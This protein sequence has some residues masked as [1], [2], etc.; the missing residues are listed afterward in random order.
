MVPSINRPAQRLLQVDMPLTLSVWMELLTRIRLCS[1][2]FSTSLAHPS[3]QATASLITTIPAALDR[4]NCLHPVRSLL[5]TLLGASSSLLLQ[6][7]LQVFLIPLR[8]LDTLLA[9]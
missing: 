3:T 7:L 5:Q 9:Q 6:V 1:V 2:A 4:D 8:W